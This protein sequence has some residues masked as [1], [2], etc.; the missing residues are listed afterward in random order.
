[1]EHVY[2]QQKAR[3]IARNGQDRF[4][5]LYRKIS[6]SKTLAQLEG[7]SIH[8]GASPN[9][10]DFSVVATSNSM[11]FWGFS[12]E[13]KIMGALIALKIWNEKINRVHSIASPFE[14]SN[15]A[16]NIIRINS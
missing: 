4:D 16:M 7:M 1:M 8:G 15:I 10:N 9:A 13:S 11:T 3:F 6:D 12:S 14:I 2:N 5:K